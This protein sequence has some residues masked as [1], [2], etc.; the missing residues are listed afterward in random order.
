PPYSASGAMLGGNVF[1]PGEDGARRAGM[2]ENV[3]SLT[4]TYDF[5]DNFAGHF[6]V[7]SAE[8]VNSGFSG[9]VKLPSY[10]LLNVGFLYHGENWQF[11]L[12]VKNITD[13]T[14]F[15]SNFPNLFGGT[16]VLPELPRHY[17]A[18]LTYN[19]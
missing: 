8:S 10:T 9:S 14:Y 16:I 13:E 3:F 11:G 1:R 12:N 4:G 17:T 7:I 6:S 5:T 18:T 19:F 15:R 2:P